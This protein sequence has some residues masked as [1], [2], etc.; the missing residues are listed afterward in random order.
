MGHVLTAPSYNLACPIL[1][2]RI[3]IGHAMVRPLL[4]FRKS[5]FDPQPGDVKKTKR[6]GMQA[7]QALVELRSFVQMG[8]V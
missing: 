6:T 3:G 5:R 7:E 4:C 2:Y 8:A 1:F